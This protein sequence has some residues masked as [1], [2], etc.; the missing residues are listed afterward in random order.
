[1]T[2]K[3]CSTDWHTHDRSSSF[4]TPLYPCNGFGNEPRTRK[5]RR[6]LIVLKSCSEI[7]CNAEHEPSETSP[8]ALLP[9]RSFS[10]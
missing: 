5:I 1:M 7:T 3:T 10:N 4:S 9:K 2:R 6:T 8:R